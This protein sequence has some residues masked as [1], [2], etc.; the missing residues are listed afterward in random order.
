MKYSECK[1]CNYFTTKP[2]GKIKSIC[3]LH[4]TEDN[5]VNIPIKKI[6]WCQEFED[7]VK[8]ESTDIAFLIN[9]PSHQIYFKLGVDFLIN[10]YIIVSM[11]CLV[12]E[13]RE[14]IHMSQSE[15]SKKTGIAKEQ[16]S[17]IENNRINPGIE[18]C[19][20]LSKALGF[21]ID[22]LWK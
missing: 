12:K 5:T 13:K 1:T 17:R 19:R 6:I 14:L 22:M 21:P 2:G 20:K 16:I 11:K 4:D 9:T 18:I 10:T 3:C 8:Q 15:L 7:Q